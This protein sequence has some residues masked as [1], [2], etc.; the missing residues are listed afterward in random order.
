MRTIRSQIMC[1]F[2]MLMSAFLALGMAWNRWENN[3]AAQLADAAFRD[4]QQQID[5]LVELKGN[6]IKSLAEDYTYWDEMVRFIHQK[7]QKWA[8]QNIDQALSTYKA[9][10]IWVYD[11]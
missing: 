3:R 10:A 7:D 9:S 2:V 1:L 6:S 4:K 8:M 5:R 11:R